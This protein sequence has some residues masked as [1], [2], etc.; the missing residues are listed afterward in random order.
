MFELREKQSGRAASRSSEANGSTAEA[1]RITT[2][3]IVA[4]TLLVC[5]GIAIFPA[6][7]ALTIGQYVPFVAAILTLACAFS[8]VAAPRPTGST[9]QVHI[10]LGFMTILGIGHAVLDPRLADF[11]LATTLLVPVLAAMI[12]DRQDQRLSWILSVVSVAAAAISPYLSANWISG[13]AESLAWSSA[14]TYAVFAL[15]VAIAAFRIGAVLENLDKAQIETFRHLIEN[16]QHVVIRLAPDAKT[17]FVSQ[18]AQT[19]FGCNRFELTGDGLV[20]RIH[21]QDRPAYLTAFADASQG[22]IARTI[23]IR[24]RR[25]GEGHSS[26]PNFIWVECGISPVRGMP[27]VNGGQEVMLLLR[28]ITQR[29]AQQEEMVRARQDAQDASEAKS[30]FLATIGHELRTPLNAIVGFSD[31]M[32]HSI[33]GELSEAHREYADLIHQSGM[34][35]LETVNMLLDMSK[36]EAGKFDL[37]LEPFTPEVLVGPCLGMVEPMARERRI[38]LTAEQAPELPRII[39]DERACRQIAINLLSNA[40]KFSHPG[41]EVRLSLQRRGNS[42]ALT[43]S[44]TGIG[45]SPEVTK[46]LGE[47]FFQAQNGL[48]RQFE[49]TGL[50]LSI[51]KGL[52]ELHGGRLAINSCLGKGTTITVLLPLDGPVQLPEPNEVVT[53]LAPREPATMR[54]NSTNLRSAAS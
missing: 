3:S 37:Q 2:I 17:L 41:G 44:D 1:I 42:L 27:I 48:A 40:V 19:L 31:M 47:P 26:V 33:A 5:A 43:V 10:L 12:G 49:G 23:E 18:S 39:G 32:S 52:V 24:M 25:D 16:I 8:I 4:R 29:M 7:W 35:L 54:G 9:R 38:D 22:G 34:H 53:R 20:E 14:G 13:E 50:G 15:I 21:V 30:R 36:I 11:G 6:T 46:R 51:V 45:M 28:D